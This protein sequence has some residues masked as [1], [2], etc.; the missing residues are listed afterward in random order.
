MTYKSSVAVTALVAA[1]AIAGQASAKE[2]LNFAYGYPNNSA[3]GLAVDA[4]AEAVAERPDGEV[5]VTGSQ[6]RC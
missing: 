4:Y 3:I 5:D 2:R 1:V 6:C